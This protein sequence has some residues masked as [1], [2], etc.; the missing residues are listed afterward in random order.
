MTPEIVDHGI[1]LLALGAVIPDAHQIPGVYFR[2]TGISTPTDEIGNIFVD[3]LPEPFLSGSIDALQ[4]GRG[5]FAIAELQF[6]LCLGNISIPVPPIREQRRAIISD[7]LGYSFDDGSY[8]IADTNI[9]IGLVLP[10]WLRDCLCFDR[11]VGIP[12]SIPIVDFQ[13][14]LFTAPSEI[15]KDAPPNLL[16]EPD[17]PVFNTITVLSYKHTEFYFILITVFPISWRAHPSYMRWQSAFLFHLEQSEE[18]FPGGIVL[19]DDLLCRCRTDVRGERLIF[20]LGIPIDCS[21]EERLSPLIV[22]DIPECR[23]SFGEFEKSVLIAELDCEGVRASH[24]E[25]IY[26]RGGTY[27]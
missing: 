23:A 9:N 20:I 4:S 7:G 18:R 21:G 3:G 25:I 26:V 2:Y 15:T 1:A 5:L 13:C 6:L 12:F 11:H 16:R 8:G 22:D 27:S 24:S 10:K 14:P 17:G 19:S